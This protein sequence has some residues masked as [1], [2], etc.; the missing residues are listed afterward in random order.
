MAIKL[1]FET[2]MKLNKLKSTVSNQYH[3][4]KT[5]L[6]KRFTKKKK[7]IERY[8][9]GA[10][11]VRFID[12]ISFIFGV[13]LLIAT[14]FLLGRYPNTHYYSFHVVTITALVIF[15]L[16]NYKKKRWHYYLFD[17]C[18]FANSIIMY[19][20]LFDPKNEILFKVFFV[21]ANGPFGI[22]IAAFKNSLIFHKIDNLTSIAIHI[23]PLV[24]AWN[25]RW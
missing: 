14:T 23:I 12:K 10:P 2:S 4:K 16:Y 19:F 21:Y 24:T 5:I 3:D 25:L 20:L 9:R 13:L 1:A 7:V 11:F 6:T 15:R 18:Y 8:I 22:A 17:F